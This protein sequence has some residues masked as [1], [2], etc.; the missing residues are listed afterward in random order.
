M[1]INIGGRTDIVNYYTPWL[2]NRLKEEYAYSRNPF[3][4]EQ[5][6]K[7]S[8]KPKD[9]DCLLFCSKNYQPILKHINNINKKYNILCNYTI[10]CYDKDI[11]PKVPSKHQSIKTLEKLSQ[12]IGKNKILWRYDP[13]LLTEKYTIEKHLETFEYMAEIIS[14]LVYRCIFSFVDMYKKVEEN[15]PEI[16]PFT[17][18]DK[19]KLLK[20]IGEISKKYNL[21]TQTCATNENYE[22]YNIH[23][24]GCTTIE[25]LQQAHNVVYKNV[26]ETGIRKNCHCIP[27][28][29]IGAYN[30]CLSECKYCY[31]NRK[32]DIP[33]KVI[34]LHDEKSPLLLGHLKE[35]DNLIETKIIRYSEPK[36]TTLFEF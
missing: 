25:I 10:T 36:Q 31:A 11:E 2:L 16:I 26:K 9:V 12:I 28:R 27:S 14:P 8:L 32:P 19:V 17:Q 5:V 1:I 35:N 23:S 24:A 20:G 33:K 4:K 13:I 18:K 29:D 21:H 30:S 7:L 34:K 22:K 3:A 15:M 6:Y